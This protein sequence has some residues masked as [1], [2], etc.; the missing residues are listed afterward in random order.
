MHFK[1]LRVPTLTRDVANDLEALLTG[2]TGVE[3]FDIILD[4]QELTIVF[5]EKQLSFRILVK[6]LNEAG[7]S[8]HNIDAALLF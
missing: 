3:R 2:L 8:L 1:A 6:K 5:D 7:C 4:T